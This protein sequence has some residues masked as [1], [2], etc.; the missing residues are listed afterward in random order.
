[1]TRRLWRVFTSDDPLS[2]SVFPTPLATSKPLA[3]FSTPYPPHPRTRVPP[4][5]SYPPPS[6]PYC[7]GCP[8]LPFFPSPSLSLPT[9]VVP[10][11]LWEFLLQFPSSS[12]LQ[13]CP[14]VRLPRPP[15]RRF[16]RYYSTEFYTP[17]L[18]IS[19]TGKSIS[20]TLPKGHPRTVL[21]PGDSVQSDTS[22]RLITETYRP[23]GWVGW[24]VGGV[25]GWGG[26]Q[27]GMTDI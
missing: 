25:S 8:F 4:L 14:P 13:V 27:G 9:L 21:P 18:S 19:P 10:A 3:F 2:Q 7:T 6:R 15:A 24:W 23:A 1:M 26:V 5:P 17:R 11:H 12:A 22:L 16:R 20:T